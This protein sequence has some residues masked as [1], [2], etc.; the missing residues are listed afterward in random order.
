[1]YATMVA[2]RRLSENPPTFSH[3]PGVE[4]NR[5]ILRVTQVPTLLRGFD[6]KVVEA[7]PS[8]TLKVGDRVEIVIA[9]DHANPVFP[10]CIPCPI[11]VPGF[12]AR[13]IPRLRRVSSLP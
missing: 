5:K 12:P 1:V 3:I 10:P 7:D 13:P 8:T 2:R 6:E 4:M 9:I 11:R